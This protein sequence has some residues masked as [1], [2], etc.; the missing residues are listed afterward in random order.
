MLSFDGWALLWGQG[1]G[2]A[3]TWTQPEVHPGQW[4]L[5][6]EGRETSEIWKLGMLVR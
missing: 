2:G 1:V 3:F 6:R 4:A 5:D